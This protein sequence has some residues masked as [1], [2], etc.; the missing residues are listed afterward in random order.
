MV[1]NSL[2]EDM[3]V[4]NMLHGGAS[5]V[6]NK[7]KKLYLLSQCIMKLDIKFNLLFLQITI[8]KYFLYVLEAM[9][10]SYLLDFLQHT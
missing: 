1:G 6:K 9:K 10:T 8:K 5:Y 3:E 7:K 2:E 4:L